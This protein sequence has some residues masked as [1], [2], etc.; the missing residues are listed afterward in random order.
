MEVKPDE[1]SNLTQAYRKL[2]LIVANCTA[3]LN[4]LPVTQWLILNCALW[5][6]VCWM[7]M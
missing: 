1:I 2:L 5:Y 4:C 7:F 3:K 6:V